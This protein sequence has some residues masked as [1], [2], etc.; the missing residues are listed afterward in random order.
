MIFCKNCGYEGAYISN[1]CPVCKQA[2][3]LSDS[4]ISEIKNNIEIAAKRKETETVIESYHILAD[5][6]DTE[7]EREWAKILEKGNG[8]PQ[9]IDAAMDFYRRAAEKFDPLSAYKYADLLSRINENISRFWL[10]FSA[11]LDYPRAYFDAAKSHIKRGESEFA[12]HYLYL[13]AAFDDVDAIVMLAERYYKGE[14]IEKSPEIAKWYMERLNFPPLYALR[15]SL[16]LRSVKAKEAPN[17]SFKDRRYLAMNL[18]GK[19]RK[20][21]LSHPVFYLTLFLFEEGEIREGAELGEMYLTGYGTK[22]SSE[23]GI[24]CLSRAAA[25]GSAR[26]YMSLGKIYFEGQHAERSIKLSIEC[27]EKAAALGLSDACEQLGDIYHNPEFENFSIPTALAY[28][29]RSADMG[30][31]GARKKAD[32]ILEVR[33]DFYRRAIEATKT[34]PKESY[35]CR[36]AGAAMGHPGAKLLLAE[37]YA[38]GIGTAPSRAHAF[39]LWKSAADDDADRAYFPLGVCYAY[40]FGT[41]F[42]FDKA[43]RALSIADKRG[44]RRA[45]GEVQRLLEN[46]KRALAKKFYSTAMRLIYIGK[47]D[48]AKNYLEA[49]T[50]LSSPKAIYTLGCLYEFGKGT[51]TDKSEAYRL[52]SVADKNGFSDNRSKFKLTI[53]KML[54]SK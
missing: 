11:F 41:A 5:C 7:G 54:K 44:D 6:G 50:D 4:E 24:R 51:H 18:L 9:D 31:A 33:E 13:A 48:K 20:L 53:L 52:Y 37:S 43:L 22:Q 45:R 35:K 40:G 38:H 10:E 15:L 47:F 34:N 8:V 42:D 46:K 27:F 2:F 25:S 17:I 21:G 26:A 16:K 39:S 1:L 36:L 14:G 3:S 23:Q 28:Y 30:S 49:A 12:N 29:R 32:K 19:A